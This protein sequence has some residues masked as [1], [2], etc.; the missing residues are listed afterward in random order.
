MKFRD[1]TTGQIYSLYDIQKKFPTVSFPTVWDTTTFNFTNVDPVTII[2]QPEEICSTKVE[3]VG[4]ELVNGRW[5]DAW[6]INPKY[7]DPVQQAICETECLES[8][9]GTIRGERDRLISMTDY[10]QLPDT[11]I[12]SASKA[13]FVTYRQTLRDI[14]NQAD[15][16]N[17]TWP[18]LPIYE[19]Q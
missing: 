10:T 16:Y 1:R 3:Y 11:P 18:T 7:N 19:K 14:T 13:A 12:T 5:Q 6:Q 2:P 15:P 8:Q 4:T 9:W 17:I